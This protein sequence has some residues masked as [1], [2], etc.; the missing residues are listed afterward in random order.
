LLVCF[1]VDVSGCASSPSVLHRLTIHSH[2]ALAVRRCRIFQ[3]MILRAVWGTCG[4]ESPPMEMGLGGAQGLEAP[5]HRAEGEQVASGAVQV[6]LRTARPA[7][8]SDN[9]DERYY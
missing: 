6:V 7:G 9:F 1:D 2:P 4:F 5:T 3:C 8:S